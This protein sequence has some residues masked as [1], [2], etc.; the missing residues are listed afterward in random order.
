MG[1]GAY[2]KAVEVFYDSDVVVGIELVLEEGGE[3]ITLVPSIKLGQ[4]LREKS[5]DWISLPTNESRFSGFYGIVDKTTG[6]LT[7]L[8]F[9]LAGQDNDEIVWSTSNMQVDEELEDDNSGNPI[10]IVVALVSFVLFWS[11]VAGC[12]L[13][14]QKCGRES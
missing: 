10:M 14:Y 12:I 3:D 8:G 1:L 11:A 6:N 2:V 4:T 5:K 7:Y 9:L 13:L